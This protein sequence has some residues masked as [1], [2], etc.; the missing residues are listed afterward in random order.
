MGLGLSWDF[1]AGI[2]EGHNSTHGWGVSAITSTLLFLLIVR[3]ERE[4]A[5][6]SPPQ[7]LSLVCE[8]M[9]TLGLG[10]L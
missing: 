4:G 5:P 1:N 8:R 7:A 3:E 10:N 2:L 6:A 9:E